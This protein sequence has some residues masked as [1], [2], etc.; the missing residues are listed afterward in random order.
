MAVT[1]K[2]ATFTLVGTLAYLGTRGPWLGR[3][4]R[5][6]LSSGT[7]RPYGHD[8]PVVWGSAL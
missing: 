8:I 3:A 1:L 4:F 7:N 6:L 2:M 5:F